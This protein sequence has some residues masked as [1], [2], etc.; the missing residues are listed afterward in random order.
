ML[1]AP[2]TIL[3]FLIIYANN[4]VY[5]DFGHHREIRFAEIR[6]EVTGFFIFPAAVLLSHTLYLLP[7]PQGIA[8]TPLYR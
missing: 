4:I 8:D 2:R 6:N 1:N 7:S 3:N 5:R